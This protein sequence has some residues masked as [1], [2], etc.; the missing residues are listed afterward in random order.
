MS[1]NK[2]IT[3]KD[4]ITDA[5]EDMGIDLTVQMPTFMRWAYRA[6]REIHSYYGWE[7]KHKVLDIK[8]CTA[9][10][11]EDTQLVQYAIHGDHG[12]DCADL[13]RKVSTFARSIEAT[14]NE[15]YIVIDRPDENQIGCSN[16]YFEVQ[17]NKMVFRSNMDGEKITIQYLGLKEDCDGF[18]MVS[19]NHIEAINYYIKYRYA[20]R[21]RFSPIKMDLADVAMNKQEY[22]R[23]VSSARADDA[24]MSPTE[25]DELVKMLHDPYIGWGLEAG[26]R[27]VNNFDTTY[28]AP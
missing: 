7:R 17:N 12:C 23:K 14:Q 5:W 21:S 1:I 22:E 20:Q 10:L 2:F 3:I 6:E 24:M 26:M 11:P 19:E 25:R 18:L 28:G 4:A 8:G 9:Q 16:M 15:I 13:G 27:S